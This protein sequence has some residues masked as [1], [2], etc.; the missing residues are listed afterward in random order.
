M[1]R[2]FYEKKTLE[3]IEKF[4]KENGFRDSAH[5][6]NGES[7][8]SLK[9]LLKQVD[10]NKLSHGLQSRFHGD[11]IMDNIV[12]TEDGFVLIDWRQDFGGHLTIGDR[13]Y[14]LAKLNHNLTVNHAV[15]NKNLFSL[16]AKGTTIRCDIMRPNTLVECQE[17]FKKFLKENGYDA[18]RVKLL[19]AI[20]WL[21]MAPL[22]HHPFNLFLYYFGK[23]HLWQA[24]Q[25]K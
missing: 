15:I 6:I 17:I 16:E 23:L 20:I 5:I 12:R 2:S 8:P 9:E 1:C 7:V 10:F 18:D 19:T 11:L 14:D 13:Y 21:N 3:R 25:K 22:H 4:F 24:L